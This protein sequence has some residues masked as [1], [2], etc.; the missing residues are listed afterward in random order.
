MS[1]TYCFENNV[2]STAKICGVPPCSNPQFQFAVNTP[3]AVVRLVQHCDAHVV[4]QWS[5]LNGERSLA[6][7]FR[8]SFVTICYKMAVCLKDKK[9]DS[10][11]A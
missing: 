8:R 6:K 11:R 4:E 9:L 2:L 5:T 7:Y 10:H 3:S 1:C